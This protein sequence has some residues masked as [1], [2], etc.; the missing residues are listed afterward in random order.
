MGLPIT[1]FIALGVVAGAALAENVPD[2]L[3]IAGT[4]AAEVFFEDVAGWTVLRA[5]DSAHSYCV[6][7][8]GL[9][10]DILRLG[11]DGTAWQVAVPHGTGADWTGFLDI[12]G[13][14]RETS[15]AS[16]GTWAVAGIDAQVLVQVAAGKVL[17]LDLG[18]GPWRYALAGA[19]EAIATLE[20]CSAAVQKSAQ[21]TL[22]K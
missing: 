6:A 20:R 17:T 10:Q 7:E 12:D 11:S 13:W 2:G 3:A 1:Q 9:G 19:P 4:G 15:G 18:S 22:V 5:G 14:N 21:A 8:T 16:V